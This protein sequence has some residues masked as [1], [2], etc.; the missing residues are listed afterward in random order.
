MNIP[1][2]KSRPQFQRFSRRAAVLS[3]V[4]AAVFAA[5][6]FLAFFTR[7]DFTFD[8]NWEQHYLAWAIDHANKQGFSGGLMHRDRIVSFQVQI[9]S[10]ADFPREWSMPYIL[11][12]G[13]RQGETITSYYSTFRQV[14]E[15]TYPPG[16]EATPIQGWYGV[17]ARL[18]LLIAI[19]NGWT[20][21]AALYDWLQPILAEWPFIDEVPDL[22]RRAGWAIAR[23]EPQYGGR[24]LLTMLF[25]SGRNRL[26]ALG[27]LRELADTVQERYALVVE[28][29]LLDTHTMNQ[30]E[31]E[32]LWRRVAREG[33][34]LFGTLP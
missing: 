15:S 3:L 9:M 5:A 2:P 18:M 32:P 22:L 25:N 28:H 31:Y 30:P 33:I 14:Y 21:A 1:L 10:S 24:L 12:V 13:T 29:T 7:N 19:E 27:S 34:L 20:G 11:A 16:S 6:Y 4:H 17:D 23:E 8:S 26:R